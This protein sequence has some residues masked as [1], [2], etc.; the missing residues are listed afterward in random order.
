M[1]AWSDDHG[2]Y[3]DCGGATSTEAV[4]R[5]LAYVNFP[6]SRGGYLTAVS[7]SKS[8]VAAADWN[9]LRLLQCVRCIRQVEY[10]RQSVRPGHNHPW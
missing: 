4:N 3:P 8:F 5:R 2:G 9:G 1:R 6:G 7:R 10:E